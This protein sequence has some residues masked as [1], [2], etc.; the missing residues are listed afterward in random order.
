MDWPDGPTTDRRDNA[1]GPCALRIPTRSNQD[2]SIIRLDDGCARSRARSDGGSI[3]P[4]RG[5]VGWREDGVAVEGRPV[6]DQEARV[7]DRRDA[8]GEHAG[9]MFGPWRRRAGRGDREDRTA[10]ADTTRTGTG[11]A[12][13]RVWS[14]HGQGAGAEQDFEMMGR[15]GGSIVR[16]T[17]RGQRGPRRERSGGQEPEGPHQPSRPPGGRRP[18]PDRLRFGPIVA[19]CPRGAR[20]S[21]SGAGAKLP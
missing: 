6:D 16:G 10:R 13:R 19:K 5:T 4:A 21:S 11:Q 1:N 3:D 14:G 8:I 18:H 7:G 20:R 17:T 15:Q 2:R 12:G 9:P